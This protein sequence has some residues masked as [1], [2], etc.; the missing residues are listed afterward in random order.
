MTWIR[1]LLVALRGR[2][3][4]QWVHKRTARENC[5]RGV[6]QQERDGWDA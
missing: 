1:N 4:L 5:L 6:L 2:T 3:A